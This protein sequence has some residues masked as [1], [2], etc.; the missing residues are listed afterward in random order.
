[1]IPDDLPEERIIIDLDEAQKICKKTGLPLVKM[2]EEE[3]IKLAHKS[4]SYYKKVFV[5][6]KYAVKGSATSGVKTAPAPNFAIPGGCYDESFIT[7]IICDRVQMHIPFYR[8]EEDLKL[9]KIDISRQTLNKLY[10]KAAEVFKPV[11]DLMKTKALQSGIIFTDD[12]PVKLQMP[13]AGKLKEGRMWVYVSGGSIHQYTLFDFTTDRRKNRPFEF[14]K[15]FE[16]YVHADAYSGYDCLFEQENVFECAC[17]MH[18][19][20][21]FFDAEDAPK[22]LRNDVLK[23]IRRIYR[24]ERIIKNKPDELKLKVRKKL[25]SKAI[26]Q[27]LEITEKALTEHIVLPKSNFGKAITYLHNLGDAVYTFTRD[28]RLSPDNGESERSLRPLTIGRKNW[29]F[30]GS[31]K[32]GQATGI[33]TSIVQTCRKAGINPREYVVDV[34]RRISDHKVSKLDELLPNTDWKPKSKYY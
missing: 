31:K 26:D 1:M 16:G 2:G 22:Q 10:M 25:S 21:K 13:G 9:L 28:I 12:T 33:L 3:T 32:G 19:R 11:Y 8:I 7:K 4:A 27:I 14:L 6:Y 30:A 29:M 17:W 23:L 5:R 18:I 20:R 34:L 15:G 24:Y